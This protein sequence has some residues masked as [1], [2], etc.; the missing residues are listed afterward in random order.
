MKSSFL[1][2]EQ[3]R[4]L[5]N[6]VGRRRFNV[7]KR[8]SQALGACVHCTDSKI[9]GDGNKWPPVHVNAAKFTSTAYVLSRS[10]YF[11]K[12]RQRTS[13]PLPPI[14]GSRSKA[15][16]VPARRLEPVKLQTSP[17]SVLTEKSMFGVLIGQG[18]TALK[19]EPCNTIHVVVEA[20]NKAPIQSASQPHDA[21][22]SDPPVRLKKGISGPESNHRGGEHDACLTDPKQQR[23]LCFGDSAVETESESCADK[24]GL[25][26]PKEGGNDDYY[27]DQRISEWILKVNSCLFSKGEKEL[28]EPAHAQVHDVATIKIIYSGE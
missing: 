4:S 28:I 22:P 26:T 11:Q 14:N 10:G 19:S 16:P 15:D 13:L 2:N 7:A 17:G 9:A 1:Q 27:N 5:L 23:N 12:P 25:Q 8:K 3:E 18:R 21:S 6:K 20:G 24:D